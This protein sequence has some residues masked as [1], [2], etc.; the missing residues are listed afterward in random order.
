[1]NFPLPRRE[2]EKVRGKKLFSS[3]EGDEAVMGN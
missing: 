2:R 3:F 1:M